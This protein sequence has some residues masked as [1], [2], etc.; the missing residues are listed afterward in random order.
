MTTPTRST[1]DPRR[2]IGLLTT[3]FVLAMLAHVPT[4][5]RAQEATPE[6][7]FSPAAETTPEPTVEPTTVPA[8][9]LT[10][11]RPYLVPIAPNQ[12]EITPILTSG[13]AVGD[14]Q[15]AG[16]PDGLGAYQTDEGVVVFMN[17]EWRTEDD[18]HISD[19]RVSRLVLDPSSAGVLSG[20]YP[21]DGSE[22]YWSFCSAFLAGPE[23]GFDQPVFLTGEESTGGEHG[24]L[25][26]A[27][28]GATGDV[29]ELPWLGHIHHENQVVVPGFAGKTV[30]VT[31]DDDSE[32][33]E[34]YLFVADSPADVLAGNGQLYVFKADNGANTADIAK[35]DDL[36]GSFVPVDEA[37]NA[38][39]ES[40][41]Q[42]VDD[43]GAF[44][45]VRLEDAT[46]DR[47]TTTT[48]YF[49]DTGDD[50]EP[51]LAADGT[52]LTKN[53]R[54]YRMA[55]DPSDPTRVTSFSVLLDGDAGDDIRNPDNI[56]AD[57]T[58]IML[59]EDLNDYN[60][61]EN[62]DA[63]GRIL[64]YDLASG[65]LTPIAQIDQSDDPDLLVDPGD[66]AGS[67]E[68]S[69]I[70]DVSAIFGPGA[71]LVDVQ[72]HTLDVPQFD[73]VDEGG[74]LLLIR[75]T[76]PSPATP[77]AP[78]SPVA[79]E[80]PLPTETSA[81]TEEA[82]AT[83]EPTAEPTEEP[84][85]EP[86]EEPTAEPTAEPTEEPTAEPTE[87]PTEEASPPA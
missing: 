26:L 33:S 27:V 72:A 22:G 35:G 6:L 75:W 36:T 65:D 38:D 62:S 16:T 18:E 67:W 1:F 80:A 73:G 81:A 42:A 28:D 59:Q 61:A 5:A 82:T 48:I 45:F 19:A 70:I 2:L 44:K 12:V 15:M 77:V 43:L 57:A 21:I 71:W 86:T 11:A 41:Q 32:G 51:N 46:Y 23:V 4:I 69:G 47:T 74:Q 25:S 84:T 50:Q 66:E 13:E 49:A 60:R 37:D 53:G 7:L 20:N 55:L 9:E 10:Q 58:T 83:T 68:S 79:T 52:P 64:A 85:A 34:L 8:G 63:T 87:E 24:G 31:T 29:T 78:A 17:H 3:V 40:L 39:A 76:P 56:D 30:V 54:L 14:Y